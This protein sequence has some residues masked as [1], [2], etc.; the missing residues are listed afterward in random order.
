MRTHSA[1]ILVCDCGRTVESFEPETK[2]TC[3]RLLAVKGW[4]EAA[5]VVVDGRQ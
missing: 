2:C 3:G 5:E 1:Y 4:G